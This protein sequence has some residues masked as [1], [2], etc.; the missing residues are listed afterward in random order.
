MART[1]FNSGEQ[2]ASQSIVRA[3]INTTTAAS[4]LITK[5]IVGNTNTT[6]IA[7][8]GVDS[9]TGDVTITVAGTYDIHL[10]IQ[11]VMTNA[12]VF[13]TQATRAFTLP[14]GLTGS[15]VSAATAAT[16][17][18]VFTFKQNGTS[19]GTAT[20][21]AAGTSATFS[22]TSSITFAAGDVIE[23]DG[24]STADATLANINIDLAGSR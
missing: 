22:F 19:I 6:S 10:I 2:T 18:T 15:F 3:D 7:S 13:R 24:P 21:A 4:A 9:G 5:V 16:A 14:S 8:T 23:V 17:S 12:E 11:G 20:F 1:Q